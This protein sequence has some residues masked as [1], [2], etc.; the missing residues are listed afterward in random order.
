MC[1]TWGLEPKRGVVS[2]VSLIKWPR[3]YKQVSASKQLLL[4]ILSL[5]LYSSF[6]TSRA[7]FIFPA[8]NEFNPGMGI[9][10][11]ENVL[12]RTLS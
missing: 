12:T 4:F 9:N 2:D 7:D 11:T 6:I 5:R 8:Q 10:M 1:S 3:G